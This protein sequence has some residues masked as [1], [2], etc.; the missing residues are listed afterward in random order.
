MPP[1]NQQGSRA[2]LITTLVVFAVLFITSSIFAF[3]FYGQAQLTQANYDAY[4]KQYGDIIPQ[5]MLSSPNVEALRNAKDAGKGGNP[6][7]FNITPTDSLMDVAMKQRDGLATV[8]HGSAPSADNPAG[9]VLEESTKALAD[10]AKDLKDAGVSVNLPTTG[11]VPALNSLT[12]ATIANQKLNANLK[13]QLEEAKEKLTQAEAATAAVN[14]AKDA[15]L[16]N[17]RA[18]DAAALDA[19]QKAVADAKSAMGQTQTDIAANGTAVQGQLAAKDAEA[20]GLHQQITQLEQ[21]VAKLKDRVSSRRPSVENAAVRQADGKLVRVASNG[22]CY[23][24]LGFG[25][26]VTP[27]LTFEVYDKA[28]GVPPIPENATSEDQMPVGKGSIEI[29]HV[30]TT[31]S[32]CRIIKLTPGA[33]LTEGDLIAN[34]VYDPHTKYNFFVFGQFDLANNGHP[35]D[36]DAEVIK[37]LITQWGGKLEDKVDVDTDFVILGAEPVV[38]SFAKDDITA[39][40]QKKIDDAQARLAKYQEIEAQAKDLHIPIMNQNRFLYYVGFYDQAKR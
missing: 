13:M 22:V 11:L 24:N 3:H 39:E 8:I 30:G 2:G 15:E 10:R 7:S 26:Q 25:D 9:P 5:P 21:L 23:I 12:L 38:P 32:E 6:A 17:V 36:P 34:L 14:T 29:T 18:A 27:G 37:R 35:N 16:A 1:I 31:S 33:V 40:N 19:A 28:D 20:A 4:K